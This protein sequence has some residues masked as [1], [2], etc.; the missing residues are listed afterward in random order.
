MQCAP[1]TESENKCTGSNRPGLNPWLPLIVIAVFWIFSFIFIGI[2]GN[3]PLNDDWLYSESVKH[4][5]DTGH[6]RMLSCSPACLLH[7]ALAAGVCKLFGFSYTIL[8][9]LGFFWGVV[10]SFALYG[11]CRRLRLPRRPALLMTL[12]FAA[13]PLL[14][15][16]AFSF[17]TDT[18]AVALTLAYTYFL[19]GGIK[20]QKESSFLFAGLCLVAA[21][22]IRQN[23]AILA[24]VNFL[25]LCCFWLRKKHSWTL[26]LALVIAPIAAGYLVD[27]WMLATSD[28]T[29]VYIW[30]RS[31]AGKQVMHLLHAPARNLP[32]LIQVSGELLVYLGLFSLPFLVSFLP[33]LAR[34]FRNKGNIS[35][36]LPLILSFVIVFSLCRF[37]L[38]ENRLMPFSQNII[39]LP[40]LGAHSI[41]GINYAV[42][43]SSW[44]EKLTLV[45]G[46]SGFILGTF[47]LDTIVRTVMNL[48]RQQASSKWR[49]SFA[50][51]SERR[52][53]NNLCALAAILLFLFAFAF[54]VLQSTFCD[55]DRYYIFPFL[56]LIPVMALSWRF[57]RAG[58][59]YV[60]V[61]PLWLALSTYSLS[62]TQDIMAWNRARWQA[63]ARL[64]A[65]G[66]N[67]KQIDGGAEYNYERDPLLSKN[68]KLF[69]TCYE[70]THRG[71]PPRSQWRWWGVATE[72]Y[73]ISFSPVPGYEAI[74]REKYWSALGG[75]REIL[76]LHQMPQNPAAP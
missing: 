23:L 71:Q 76:T 46:F 17:M 40:E 1:D 19:L 6:I 53:A 20:R 2:S 28:F 7:V 34:F 70:F 59:S 30:Y 10:A 45:S 33:A 12:C 72:E 4:Y 15:C 3:F 63:I 18:P 35:P 56:A 75:N 47:I 60:L 67:Y 52:S 29:P 39:R 36:A 38:G 58:I 73:I 55:L 16:L 5:L 51:T 41:L 57:H 62:A 43:S 25:L 37:V 24:C 68:L 61:L 64:E 48:F 21:T 8:R 9:A 32:S 49:A 27:K 50:S 42:L 69:D 74:A 31:M 65:R 44:R 22:C 26:L 66:I 14:L 54:N 13:N 11:V